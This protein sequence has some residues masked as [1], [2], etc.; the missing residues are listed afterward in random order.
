MERNTL[1]KPRD[2]AQD[3]NLSDSG[4]T[5]PELKLEELNMPYAQERAKALETQAHTQ[6][7]AHKTLRH[8]KS[9]VGKWTLARHAVQVFVLIFFLIPVIASG[10]ALA[11]S[12]LTG[13][14]INEAQATPAQF[15]WYGTL[16]SST[17]GPIS[18]LDPFVL[19]QIIAASKS[20]DPAWLIAALPP[21]LFFGLVRGRAFCGWVCPVNLVL[22]IVDALRKRIHPKKNLPERKLPRHTK[23]GLTLGILAL[24]AIVSMPVYEIFNPISFI[25]KGL[26][27]GSAVGGVTLAAIILIDVFWGHRVWCRSLCPLG[28]FYEA[29]G[30]LGF[31]RVKIKHE[32]CI[33][34]GQCKKACIVDP[35]ILDPSIEGKTDTVC[36]GDCMICGKCIDA[37]PAKALSMKI[38]LP[39]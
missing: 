4:P 16:S 34:C 38:G 7:Q 27:F 11:G 2:T 32:A 21:L 39:K 35:E 18:L 31:A 20:F 12:D 15:L 8:K 3:S 23:I 10:W 14:A 33:N 25:N 22:E 36:A 9:G 5:K 1:T 29:L 6:A 30:K 17:I 13:E 28:G 24:S 37:C 19:L 26:V